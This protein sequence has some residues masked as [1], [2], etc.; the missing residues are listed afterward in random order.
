MNR[1][2]RIRSLSTFF[3]DVTSDTADLYITFVDLVGSTQYKSDLSESDQPDI[4][5]ITRQLIFLQRAA[6]II[7]NHQGTVVKTIGDEVMGFFPFDQEPELVLK[8]AIEIIQAF[9]NLK[10]YTGKSI[11]K[12]KVAL[13][14]GTTY[15]GNILNIPGF[16]P[17]GTCVDRCA[18]MNSIAK[19]DEVL[20]SEDFYTRLT[21]TTSGTQLVHN[22]GIE[23]S[24]DTELKGI[25]N[26]VVYRLVAK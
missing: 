11:I 3:E 13:D 15:N 14:Y 25:G 20:M 23:P 22:Y 7:S 4:H 2:D 17:V 8:S 18:R 26:A 21:S 9:E 10:F 24:S 16:D 19:K 1:N 5:W 6:D 12:V